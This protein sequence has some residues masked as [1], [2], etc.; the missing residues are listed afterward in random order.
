MSHAYVALGRIAYWVIWPA[1]WL[2]LRR[3]QRT[4]LLLVCQDEVLVVQNWLGDG[5]FGL[6]GGGLHS[7]EDPAAG[8][9]RE[10]RE[11]T[12]STISLDRLQYLAVE[13]YRAHGFR[14]HCHYFAV[15]LAEKPTVRAQKFEIVAVAWTERSKLSAKTHGPDV[16][17][18]LEL[19]DSM[20]GL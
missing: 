1:S 4:R 11:E 2:Y 17:R 13:P 12:G 8:V 5:R 15:Q 6:P 7:G 3:S 20:D 18:A 14:Y 19:L 10:V 9:I 16:F